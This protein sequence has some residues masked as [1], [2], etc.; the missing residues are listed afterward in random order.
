[1]NKARALV[2]SGDGLNCE[3]ETLRAFKLAGGTGEIIHINTLLKNPTRIHEFNILA[4][5]GGFSFGDEINSGQV[6]SLKIKYSLE[7]EFNLFISQDNLVIGICNGFQTLVKLGVFTNSSDKIFTLGH[8]RQEHFIDQWTK[9]KVEKSKCVWTK[10][11]K[12]EFDLPIR[13]AEGKIFYKGN[14][15]EQKRHFNSMKEN[16]QI[17]LTYKQDVN[18]SYEQ[19]AGV[20]DESGRIFG[21]M[22]HP[23]AAVNELTNP[24]IKKTNQNDIG[25]SLFKNAVNYIEN[26][27]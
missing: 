14:S 2:I 25:L 9:V 22:P 13:H 3:N 10:D 16:G 17:A 4:I 21:L 26:K 23:E 7:K 12:P 20:C 24:Y 5:P 11:L 18:G 19:I 1:M 27:L 6:L 15:E 8:N